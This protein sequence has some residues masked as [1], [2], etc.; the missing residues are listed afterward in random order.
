MPGPYRG[1]KRKSF[2]LPASRAK[3]ARDFAVLNDLSLSELIYEWATSFVERGS[4]YV[5]DPPEV[6]QAIGEPDIWAAA[7][8][9]ARDE[10]G[11]GFREVILFEISEIEKL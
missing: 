5:P 1:D 9:R 3:L 2:Q 10:F 11:V 7:E 8:R 6:V 4:D